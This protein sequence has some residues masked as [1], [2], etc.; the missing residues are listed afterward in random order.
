MLP[1]VVHE[2]AHCYQVGDEYD[3]GS[4]N[5]KVNYPPNGF[6][7]SDFVTGES[8]K[9]SGAAKYWQTPLQYKKSSS[10]SKKSMVNPDGSAC[11]VPLSLHPYS[12]SQQKYILGRCGSPDWRRGLR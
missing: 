7:G 5:N 6:S 3:G 1:T 4:F 12:L 11:I 8:I 10:G 2:I 9:T